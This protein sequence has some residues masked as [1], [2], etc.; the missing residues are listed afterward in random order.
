[1]RNSDMLPPSC[2]GILLSFAPK[3]EG[4]K[5]YVDFEQLCWLLVK[6]H[7]GEMILGSGL[8]W[9]GDGTLG[10]EERYLI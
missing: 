5:Y 3:V 2:S 4:L 1:M 8:F 6:Y 10:V 7:T 9:N